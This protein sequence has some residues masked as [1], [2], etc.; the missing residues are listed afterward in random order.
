MKLLDKMVAPLDKAL[1]RFDPLKKAEKGTGG[2]RDR[3]YD[4]TGVAKWREWRGVKDTMV[5]YGAWLNNILSMV[6]MVVGA[7]ADSEGV[8]GIPLDG[9]LSGNLHVHRSA[10]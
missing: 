3:Y 9:L 6:Q 2:Q 5:D 8:L 4:K 7:R 1:E 10:F